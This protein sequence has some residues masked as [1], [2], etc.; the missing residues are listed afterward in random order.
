LSN[1]HHKAQDHDKPSRTAAWLEVGVPLAIVLLV[2]FPVIRRALEDRAN[3]E[4]WVQ[5]SGRV[6]ATRITIIGSHD[7]GPWRAGEIDYIA[8]AHVTYEKDGAPQD[9]WLPASEVFTSRREL[10]VWLSQKKTG[11]CIVRWNAL[12][13]LRMRVVLS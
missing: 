12:N 1:H 3:G 7:R 13:P 11:N 8:E 4:P 9:R 10:E 2:A 6:L 5:V